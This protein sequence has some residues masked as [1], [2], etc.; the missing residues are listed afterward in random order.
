MLRVVIAD[1][2]RII[3]R[4]IRLIGNWEEN[5]MEIVGEA[6]NGIEAVELFK[7]KNPDVILL[8][9]KMPGCSGDQVLKFIAEEKMNPS[10][11][12]ISGY[13]DFQYARIALKYGA[14]DYILKPIN[15]NELNQALKKIYE[16]HADESRGE[17][18]ERRK[19]IVG[20][21]RER[22]D[23]EYARD[24]SLS[25][26]AQEYYMNKDV[27]SRLFKKKY[28]V[29]ITSYINEVRLAQAKAYLAA[30]YNIAEA[31][32]LVGY[33]DCSYFSRV[34]KKYCGISPKQFILEGD[35]APPVTMDDG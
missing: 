7:A 30:G 9:M 26:L 10:V 15:R 20:Q 4:T 6:Q 21:I 25:S 3:R 28:G 24:I 23:A 16:Q 27:L 2:E 12:V 17:G 1:D 19:D 13:D 22:I 5:N 34:F 35:K 18:I 32:E 29:N 8:D 31:A 33:H 11:I 14:V